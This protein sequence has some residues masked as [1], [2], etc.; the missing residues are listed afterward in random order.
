MMPRWNQRAVF[1][2]QDALSP[3]TAV[4]TVGGTSR[5]DENE[6]LLSYPRAVSR[7]PVS[8]YNR[9]TLLV[10]KLIMKATKAEIEKRNKEEQ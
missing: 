5:V 3:V 9:A 8:A 7:V 2:V 1:R 6:V 10:F 4:R